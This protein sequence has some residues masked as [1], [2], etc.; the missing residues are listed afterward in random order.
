MVLL[1]V[2]FTYSKKSSGDSVSLSFQALTELPLDVN[3]CWNTLG[4]KITAAGRA[5]LLSPA[6]AIVMFLVV[7]LHP[8]EHS[9]DSPPLCS[10][11]YDRKVWSHI[12]Y[13]FDPEIGLDP[14]NLV[15]T[16]SFGAL[17]WI[18]G[19]GASARDDN[20]IPLACR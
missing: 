3:F 9:L 2:V 12:G 16:C 4:A 19:L 14:N 7:G 13:L 15:Y 1:Q 11:D 18:A 20:A 17:A 10:S 5:L 6:F 8:H